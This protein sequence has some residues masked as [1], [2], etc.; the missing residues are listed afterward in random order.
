MDF[1]A[2][3]LSDLFPPNQIGTW[4]DA[5]TQN[6]QF[7][8]AWSKLERRFFKLETLQE[9]DETGVPIY[10][11]WR[12]GDLDDVRRLASL[13]AREEAD[14]PVEQRIQL[15]RVR[16]LRLPVSDYV[17]FENEVYECLAEIGHTILGIEESRLPSDLQGPLLDFLLFDEAL[18]FVHD[19][20]SSGVRRGS[21]AIDTS[22]AVRAYSEVAKRLYDLAEPFSDLVAK[23][24]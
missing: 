12:C 21:W 1:D 16:L 6:K 8:H 2:P 3:Y 23:H 14:D 10:E 19:Y 15:I 13:Q 18:V 22:D 20:D 5:P 24:F 4:V 9:Y 7:D 11:A 17:R